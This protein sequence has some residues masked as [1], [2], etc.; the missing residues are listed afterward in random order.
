ML[1]RRET[2][3]S[4]LY[5]VASEFNKYTGGFITGCI[6]AIDGLLIPIRSPGKQDNQAKLF[7]CRKGYTAINVQAIADSRGRF[8]YASIGI[9]PGSCHDSFAWSKDSMCGRLRDPDSAT[10]NWLRAKG[11][12]LIGDDAYPCSQ[13]MAVPWPGKWGIETPELAYNEVHSS[14][15]VSV[16]RAFGMLCRKWLLLKRP[17]ER[18]VR[19]TDQSAGIHITVKVCMLLHNLSISGGTGD[20][21][22]L[23]PTD[24]SGESECSVRSQQPRRRDHRDRPRPVDTSTVHVASPNP[25]MAAV[26]RAAGNEHAAK[27]AAG[28]AWQDDA[29]HDT[30]DVDGGVCDARETATKE[31]DDPRARETDIMRALGVVRRAE[32]HWR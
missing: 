28:P 25:A 2:D 19:R 11:L 14:A 10:A 3:P 9:I 23:Q 15:R 18:S 21:V 12:H 17:F 30:A 7:R 8:L 22:F 29:E 31:L 26:E 5:Q 24:V 1:D 6:G 20:S 16:E 32:V 13:T 4:E 27:D